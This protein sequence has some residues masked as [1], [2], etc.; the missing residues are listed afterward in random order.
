MRSARSQTPK[1]LP[2]KMGAV[3]LLVG[4]AVIAITGGWRFALGLIAGFLSGLTFRR[5]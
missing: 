2:R 5:R 4:V 1:S 3:M